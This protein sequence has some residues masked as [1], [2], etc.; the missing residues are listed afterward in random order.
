MKTFDKTLTRFLI[1]SLIYF[2]LPIPAAHAELV[3]TYR[4]TA[5]NQSE[6]ARQKLERY[7]RREDMRA[8]LERNG[9]DPAAAKARVDALADED[10]AAIAGKI[11]SL[12]AG[13]EIIGALVFIFVLLLVT[14]ILGF[15]KIYSFTRSVKK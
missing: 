8:G 4:L 10:V 14:D 7:L 11:D 13:G 3:P 1:A 9:V 15:T 12:P 5:A 6:S 2:Y